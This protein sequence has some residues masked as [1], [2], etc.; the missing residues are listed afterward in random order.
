MCLRE[1]QLGRRQKSKALRSNKNKQV[2]P[3]EWRERSCWTLSLWRFRPPP[4]APP[5]SAPALAADAAVPW[6]R[7]VEA[8]GD[9]S[10]MLSGNRNLNLCCQPELSIAGDCRKMLDIWKRQG[11]NTVGFQGGNC[12]PGIACYGK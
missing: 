12:T 5:T 8:P 1:A 11:A 10:C 9:M 4:W 6:V 2:L 7:A 3:Y